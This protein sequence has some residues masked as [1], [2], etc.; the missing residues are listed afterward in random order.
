MYGRTFQTGFI[1]ST[2]SKIRPNEYIN[3]ALLKQCYWNADIY[4]PMSR[5]LLTL[6][7]HSREFTVDDNGTIHI[8]GWA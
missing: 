6:F 4:K 7:N 5:S 8:T 2:V 1:R 3:A